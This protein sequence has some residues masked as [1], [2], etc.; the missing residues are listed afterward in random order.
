MALEVAYIFKSSH[1]EHIHSSI[2]RS[3]YDLPLRQLQRSVYSPCMVLHSYNHTEEKEADFA[4]FFVPIGG[5]FARLSNIALELV[6]FADVIELL[7]L[8]RVINNGPACESL[9]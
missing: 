1:V 8:C 7:P 6:Y 9:F 3:S 2:I 5:I 4:I